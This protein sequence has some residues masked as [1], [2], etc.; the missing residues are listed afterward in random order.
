VT[1]AGIMEQ[2]GKAV[3]GY[4]KA[5]ILLVPPPVIQASVRPAVYRYMLQD[6]EGRGYDAL[7]KVAGDVIAKANQTPGLSQVYTLFDVGTP[8]VFADVDRRKADLLR[9]ARTRVR[10]DAGLSRLRIRQR[11]QP[12][13]ADLSRNRSGR[14]RPSRFGGGHRQPQD[15]FELRADGDRTVSTATRLALSRGPL[16]PDAGGRNRRQHRA[17]L[18]D[19]AIADDDGSACRIDRAAGYGGEWTDIAFQQKTPGTPPA[20]SSPWPCS[21]SSCSRSMKA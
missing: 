1:Y 21:S 4:D 3:E 13:G 15:P 11:F 5:R 18:F 16:Q 9:A 17:G 14:C 7:N 2:A 8:R 10:S 19:R 20:W 6:R 12:S